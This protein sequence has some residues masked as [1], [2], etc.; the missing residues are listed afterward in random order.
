MAQ[1]MT[2]PEA[3]T[4]PAASGGDTP[5]HVVFSGGGTG[6]HL[7]P[8]L[9]VADELRKL[10][11]GARITFVGRGATFDRTEVTGAGYE[12]TSIRA[13]PFPRKPW[14]AVGFLANHLARSR[15]AGQFL[16]QNQVSLVVGL[17]GYVSVPVARAAAS[18]GL[19]V[20][21]LEQN[22]VAGRANRWLAPS[23]S[24]ICS[25]FEMDEPWK[26]SCPVKVV[27]N[28]VRRRF[29]QGLVHSDGAARRLIVLAGSQGAKRLNEFVPRAIYKVGRAARGWEIIHQAGKRDLEATRTLYRKLGLVARVEPFLKDLPELLASTELVVSRAGGTTLAELAASGVPAVLIPYPHA[30]RDHQRKNAD[31]FVAAGAARLID[32]RELHGRLDDRLA[33]VLGELATDQI[34]RRGMAAAMRKLARPQ[35]ARDVALLI[36]ELLAARSL[37]EA[38]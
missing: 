4:S 19:P 1:N 31:R 7:F 15:E 38:G 2:L 6:G 25:A 27:G 32:P 22:A 17:G 8:G 16:A 14:Q 24:L 11:P 9:A 33:Q 37:R 5:P 30:S 36:R 21:L 35:A 12:F 3:P 18:R 34:V 13:R 23:A 20:V 26:C 29:L 10:L 28:P